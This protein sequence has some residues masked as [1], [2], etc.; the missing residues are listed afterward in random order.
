MLKKG[1]VCRLRKSLHGLKQTSCQ[2]FAKLSSSLNN[3]GFMLSTF[4]HSLFIKETLNS[5]TIFFL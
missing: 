2:W 3:I 1:Q 5:F 4:D